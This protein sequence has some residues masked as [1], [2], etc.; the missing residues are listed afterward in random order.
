MLPYFDCRK[1]SA[2]PYWSATKMTAGAVKAEAFRCHSIAS[3]LLFE[4]NLAISHIVPAGMWESQFSLSVH[5]TSEMLSIGPWLP[6][7]SGMLSLGPWMPSPFGPVVMAQQAICLTEW[8]G[9]SFMC[10]SF[11]RCLRLLHCKCSLLFL[12]LWLVP[13][14][15]S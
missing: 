6:F 2:K 14:L 1:L 12:L 3:L 11:F 8:H 13:Q 7:T 15:I 10:K 9:I 4:K 5:S